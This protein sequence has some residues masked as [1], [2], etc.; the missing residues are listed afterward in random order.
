MERRAFLGFLG[1]AA[2]SGPAIVKS[3]AQM[4]LHDLTMPGIVRGGGSG[5][6]AAD[7][8]ACDAKDYAKRGLAKLL[9]KS[10]AQI[11]RDK[12]DT[13]IDGLDPCIA[14]LRSMALG[15]KVRLQRDINYNRRRNRD[16][17]RFR[18]ILAG[19]WD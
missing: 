13:Y 1:G 10:A 9:G 11:A 15:A 18:G 8:P 16:E 7:A 17:E 12:R 2:S 3:A 19:W 14:S 5:I 4:G 6:E